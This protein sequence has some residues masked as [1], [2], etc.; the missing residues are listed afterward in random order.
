MSL[1]LF[2]LTLAITIHLIETM[3]MIIR[4]INAIKKYFKYI[5]KEINKILKINQYFYFLEFNF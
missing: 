4:L 3:I 5:N 1:F 2:N